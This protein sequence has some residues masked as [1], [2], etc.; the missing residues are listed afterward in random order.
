MAPEAYTLKGALDGSI[1]GESDEQFRERGAEA[2]AKY[3][4]CGMGA[5]R[6]PMV[7]GWQERPRPSFPVKQFVLAGL[8]VQNSRCDSVCWC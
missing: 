1:L 8:Y 5:A 3:Q 4:K 7:T 2:Y 6:K